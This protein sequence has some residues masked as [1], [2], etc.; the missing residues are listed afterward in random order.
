[1]FDVEPRLQR[2]NPSTI[3]GGHRALMVRLANENSGW[4]IAAS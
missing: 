2:Q 4:V 3:S 1:M